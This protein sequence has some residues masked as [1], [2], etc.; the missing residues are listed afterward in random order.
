[1]NTGNEK[2]LIIGLGGAGGKVVSRIASQQISGLGLAVIDSDRADLAAMNSNVTVLEAGCN[3]SWGQGTGCGGNVIRGEQA[4]SGERQRIMEL[5]S[6]RKFIIVVAGLGGGISTGGIRTLAS[7][8]RSKK[9]PAVF[10]LTTPFSFESFSRRKAA[11]EC[12][13]QLLPVTDILIRLPN[14][15]LFSMLSPDCPVEEAFATSCDELARTAIGICGLMNC[16]NSFNVD[17]ASFMAALRGKR[18]QCA[19]GVGL[20]VPTQDAPDRS[21]TAIQKVLNSPFLGGIDKMADS[22]VMIISLFAGPGLSLGEMKRALEAVSAFAGKNTEII[23]GFSTAPFMANAIQVVVVTVHYDEV[24]KSKKKEQIVIQE[25]K[26]EQPVRR[27]PRKKKAS[28]EL[29]QGMLELTNFSKGCF[30]N[31]VP[32]MYGDQ[33]LD[34][35]TFQR[36]G[37][38]IDQGHTAK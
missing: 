5:I 20:G 30:V 29:E 34:I 9:I 26:K 3:W 38:I 10:M 8:I 18:C 1:M 19:M 25:E 24:E 32:V 2:I 16:T 28:P 35:P 36:R 22:D 6:G 11:S 21:A 27:A 13:D 37:I 33:D 15:L 4:V 7:T 17:Y 31:T 14:D 12:I 23:S